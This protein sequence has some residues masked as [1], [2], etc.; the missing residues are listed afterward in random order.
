MTQKIPQT[1]LNAWNATQ[2]ITDRATGQST[3][4]NLSSIASLLIQECGRWTDQYAS[5]FIITWHEVEKCLTA[6]EQPEGFF[7]FA[8]R[9][10]GVDSIDSFMYRIKSNATKM[11]PYTLVRTH[12]ARVYALQITSNDGLCS[13]ILKNITQSFSTLDPSDREDLPEF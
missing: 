8:I 4:V 3:C 11:R 9:S 10:M 13:C 2:T 5:D 1:I 6:S 7:L 12:Y